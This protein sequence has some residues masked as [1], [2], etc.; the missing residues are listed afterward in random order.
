MFSFGGHLLGDSVSSERFPTKSKS[1]TLV[2]RFLIEKPLY[3][4]LYSLP[5]PAVIWEFTKFKRVDLNRNIPCRH[6]FSEKSK[7]LAVLKRFAY[8]TEYMYLHRT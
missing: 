8:H 2:R 7:L 5:P 1:F 4:Y 6:E 3:I